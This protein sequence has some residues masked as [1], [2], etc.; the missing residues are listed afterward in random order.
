MNNLFIK[1]IYQSLQISLQGNQSTYQELYQQYSS[2]PPNT[3]QEI[4][5]QQEQIVLELSTAIKRIQKYALWRPKCYNLALTS[6]Q[7]LRKHNIPNQLYLGFRHEN[8]E[9]EGHAWVKVGAKIVCGER[10]DLHT[11]KSLTI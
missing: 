10:S 11:Y 9:L 6:I 2:T 8:S 3:L 7:I 4:G 5:K 1:A